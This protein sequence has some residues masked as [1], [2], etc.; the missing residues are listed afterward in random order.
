M[1][2]GFESREPND[3]FFLFF[4]YFSYLLIFLCFFL[5]LLLQCK[6]NITVSSGEPGLV[7]RVLA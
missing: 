2:P 5:S 7:D 6:F 1:C 3:F 4:F